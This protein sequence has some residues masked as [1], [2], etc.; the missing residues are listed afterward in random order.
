M[1]FTCCAHNVSLYEPCVEC[2]NLET[3][4]QTC[5]AVETK[6]N[7]KLEDIGTLYAVNLMKLINQYVTSLEMSKRLKEAKLMPAQTL[8]VYGLSSNKLKRI[9]GKVKEA[10]W[11]LYPSSTLSKCEEWVGCLTLHE[12]AE[13]CRNEYM[14]V[15][16]TPIC[17]REEWT[18]YANNLRGKGTTQVGTT[19][20]E[21]MA[22]LYLFINGHD[23]I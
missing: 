12:L 18:A 3:A 21:A 1:N 8:F 5:P 16:R 2:E 6:P 17:T 10:E 14:G 22:K 13:L 11:K 19:P 20:E 7:V 9:R 23:T 15:F 4:I